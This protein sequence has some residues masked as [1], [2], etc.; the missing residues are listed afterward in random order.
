MIV[1]RF[2][3]FVSSLFISVQQ[4]GCRHG[5]DCVSRASVLLDIWDERMKDQ[6]N[7]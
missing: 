6:R 4:P 3:P 7:E 1:A 5:E 2:S